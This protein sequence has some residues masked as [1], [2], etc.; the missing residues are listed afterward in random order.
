MSLVINNSTI[1]LCCMLVLKW[2]Y[3]DHSNTHAMKP[4]QGRI[5]SLLFCCVGTD[6]MD[7]WMA[8]EMNLR[9][10]WF[11]LE[12]PGEHKVLLVKSVDPERLDQ[13]PRHLLP[14][15]KTQNSSGF[16]LKGA[17]AEVDKLELA[18]SHLA[19]ALLQRKWCPEVLWAPQ[20]PLVTD[21][22]YQKAWGVIS[23]KH[24]LQL[25]LEQNWSATVVILRL[26]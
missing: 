26:V 13:H 7:W 4:E 1:F 23:K 5:L 21:C 24:P 22:Q 25:G 11:L 16:Y 8:L 14:S 20:G 10:G 2:I 19:R 9:D 18:S 17:P 15:M 6:C 3:D 12:V